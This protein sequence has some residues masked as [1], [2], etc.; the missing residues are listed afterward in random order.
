MEPQSRALSI[1]VGSWLLL[2]CASCSHR[3][4]IA[5]SQPDPRAAFASFVAAP[6]GALRGTVAFTEEPGGVHIVV[7][8]SSATPGRHGIHIHEKGDCT[9]P[10]FTSA[11]GHFNPSGA[12][13]ACGPTTPRHAGD[14]GNI[15]VGA[16]GTGRL[17]L[18][19]KQ[20]TLSPG[21]LSV[22]G[23]SVVIHTGADDCVSQ[24]AGDSGK[25]VACAP[26]TGL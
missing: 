25:R 13:H 14:L 9:A 17:E 7:A 10:D 12:P 3:E 24:P 1:L 8:V 5:S 22:I 4:R 6:G 20:I 19:T 21:P 26:I 18:T 11:G 16:D 2:A 15:S 23:R